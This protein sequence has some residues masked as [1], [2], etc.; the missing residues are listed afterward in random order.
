MT[1]ISWNASSSMQDFLFSPNAALSPAYVSYVVAT[2]SGRVV[3]GIIVSESATSITLRR[4][5]AI[6][7]T[8]ARTDIEEMQSTGQSLMPEGLEKNLSRQELA[9]LIEYLRQIQ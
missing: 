8:V 5:A 6:D 2:K 3:S 9:D 4:A 7:D 1:G